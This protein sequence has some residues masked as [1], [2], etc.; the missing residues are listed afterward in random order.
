MTDQTTGTLPVSESFILSVIGATGA[1][2]SIIF[3]SMRK[4]RC[5][6]IKCFCFEC[7]RDV[8]SKEELELEQPS[9]RH[10]RGNSIV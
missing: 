3:A 2:I 9:P 5:N 1:L 8:M 7:N 10:E 6:Q 4:S